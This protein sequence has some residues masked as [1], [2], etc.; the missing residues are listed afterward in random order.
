MVV[1]ETVNATATTTTDLVVERFI[2]LVTAP[3][4]HP[5]LLWI[6]IPLVFALVIMSIY[7]GRYKKEELGWNT[8]V[9]NALALVFVTM[10]LTRQVYAK[11]AEPTIWNL[12]AIQ[13]KEVL[14]IFVLALGSLWL[15]AAHFFHVL[16]RKLAFFIS[17]SL[18]NTIFAYM[19][20]ILIYTEIPLDWITVLA[21]AILFVILFVLL[22][23]IQFFIPTFYSREEIDK[24]FAEEKSR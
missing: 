6:T 8:A 22:R 17:S 3:Y 20:I 23:I 24:I 15:F 14:V 4:H 21:A 11:M 1:N 18:P 5:E 9:G 2:E 12:L 13:F 10:D 7:F 16:P 19:A